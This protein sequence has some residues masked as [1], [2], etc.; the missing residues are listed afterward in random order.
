MYDRLTGTISLAELVVSDPA[1][2]LDRVMKAKPITVYDDDDIDILAEIVAK[3]N[4]LAVPVINR[5]QQM[6]GVVVIEDIVEDLL[7]KRKTR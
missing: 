2:T 6:E 7:N 3:Y 5:S 1:M 4:L